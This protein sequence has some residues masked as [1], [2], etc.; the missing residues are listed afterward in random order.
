[1]R[2]VTASAR[3]A[4]ACRCAQVLIRA[5]LN[6]A[7]AG[8]AAVLSA[9]GHRAVVG[10]A[11]A[12]VAITAEALVPGAVGT[13]AGDAGALV[14]ALCLG[15]DTRLVLEDAVGVVGLGAGVAWFAIGVIR[16]FS[17]IVLDAGGTVTLARNALGIA[18][19]GVASGR[20]AGLGL[21]PGVRAV[22]LGAS[23]A[24]LAIGVT[25]AGLAVGLGAVA[26]GALSSVTVVNANALVG[27]SGC[28]ARLGVAAAVGGA[29]LG[30]ALEGVL[31]SGVIRAHGAVGLDAVPAIAG[32]GLASFEAA[33]GVLTS[34]WWWWGR[35][36]E[37]LA[38][39]ASAVGDVAGLAGHAIGVG[40]ADSAVVL[41][42][43]AARALGLVAGGL[44]LQLVLAGL[45]GALAGLA[46]VL[47]AVGHSA[48]G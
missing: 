21:A 12:R 23:V 30:D 14:F 1:M 26:A 4:S 25:G 41:G 31:A 20:G 22:A 34:G 45:L 44:A 48:D 29:V 27:A 7:T 19:L 17:A 38:G 39:T 9:V 43:V 2:A 47:G 37:S 32:N 36:R 16:A 8:L 15:A 33:A 35:T 10:A 11:A 3:H 46:A 6:G 42:A 13:L 40:R 24:G 18:D 28:F 5:S